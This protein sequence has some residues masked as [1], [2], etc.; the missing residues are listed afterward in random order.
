MKPTKTIRDYI[1]APRVDDDESKTEISST[2]VELSRTKLD[3]VVFD[4][5]DYTYIDVSDSIL[6]QCELN[7]VIC[8]R[9]I[10]VRVII[11]SSQ[12]TG[13]QLPE[14][15][16][17]SVTIQSSRV[18]L[19]NFRNAGLD[20]C[21]FIDCDLTEADFSGSTLT[22]VLFEECMLDTSD[23]SNCKMK[24][25]QFKNCSLAT[26]QGA[27]ALSGATI[28]NQ[29]LIEIAPLLATELKIKIEE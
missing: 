21:A 29:N 8:F 26:I 12:L 18:N 13:L 24:N 4:P 16:F 23:F 14:G 9:S 27:N 5:G 19:T 2:S 15:N 20:A 1:D 17:K 3:K 6:L 7:T 28:S 11:T 25:V 10:I 22:N